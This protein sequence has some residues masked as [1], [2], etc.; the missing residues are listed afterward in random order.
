MSE[1]R[2]P[3]QNVPKIRAKVSSPRKNNGKTPNIHRL[4]LEGKRDESHGNSVAATLLKRAALNVS[5]C[6][7]SSTETPSCTS[8]KSLPSFP[9]QRKPKKLICPWKQDGRVVPD[10]I[11][12]S[13]PPPFSNRCAWITQY[14]DPNY[15]AF[16]DNEWGVPVHDDKRLFELLVLS[17]ALAELSWSA[18][19]N[20]RD[21][22]RQVFA[23]F[24][25]AVVAT[26][27]DN[28]IESF[29]YTKNVVLHE[30]KLRG[31]VNNA[32]L[33]LKIVEEYGALD[34]YIWSFVGFKPIVN[35]FRYARQVPVRTPKAE[36]ISR[37]LLKRGFRFV[38]PTVI[39]SFMQV[40]GMTNDHLAHCFRWEESVLLAQQVGQYNRFQ[41]EDMGEKE[42][43]GILCKAY[44][45]TNITNSL[46]D[47][48]YDS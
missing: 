20:A 37:D 7:C 29:K 38:G 47:S 27:D 13:T 28:K 46:Q 35:R 42:R 31:I 33:V 36:V 8:T 45:E 14:S 17:G 21:T 18:I 44:E 5:A 4:S 25:P 40:T 2:R 43:S 9:L 23:G 15:V 39:Y 48:I 41:A 12:L 19:L 24:D 30:G 32:K 26:F 10:E 34:T 3:P 11:S 1:D 6:S 16:H 22:Y